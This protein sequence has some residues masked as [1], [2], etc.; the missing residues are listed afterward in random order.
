MLRVFSQNRTENV[1]IQAKEPNEALSKARNVVLL[2]PSTG[3]SPPDVIVA[4]LFLHVTKPH[5]FV[6][7]PHVPN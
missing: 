2:S 3:D 1:T 5:E 7:S 4:N 6:N